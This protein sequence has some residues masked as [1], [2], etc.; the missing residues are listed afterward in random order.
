MVLPLA[1]VEIWFA[2]DSPQ[3]PN[4][5]CPEPSGRRLRCLPIGGCVVRA[6][7]SA[8]GEPF[9]DA[10]TDKRRGDDDAERTGRACQKC[11]SRSHRSQSG[12]ERKTRVRILKLLL[13][14]FRSIPHRNASSKRLM[15]TRRTTK[16][17]TIRQG[18]QRPVAQ[19]APEQFLSACARS[20]SVSPIG[21]LNL[22]LVS[23]IEAP[24]QSVPLIPIRPA[25]FKRVTNAN[26][27]G[28]TRPPTRRSIHPPCW[29]RRILPAAGGS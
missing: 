25:A 20:R 27:L 23:F 5:E 16:P 12:S 6:T 29:S 8:G 24:H 13:R 7:F 17:Q 21:P 28:A 3:R 4:V 22:W 19:V 2:S 10:D 1:G 11:G 18:E 9:P 26:S 15:T 14:S